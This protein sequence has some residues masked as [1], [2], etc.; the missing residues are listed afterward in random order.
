MNQ[1]ETLPGRAC[2]ILYTSYFD[3]KRMLNILILRVSIRITK[4]VIKTILFARL[5]CYNVKL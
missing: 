3:V 5:T 2:K 4:L 1:S